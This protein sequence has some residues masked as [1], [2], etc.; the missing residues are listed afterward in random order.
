MAE[1]AQISRHSVDKSNGSFAESLHDSIYVVRESQSF[2]RPKRGDSS[3]IENDATGG[4]LAEKAVP[5]DNVGGKTLWT[6]EKLNYKK[7]GEWTLEHHQVG[8]LQK[9]VTVTSTQNKTGH[10]TINLAE[11]HRMRLRKLQIKLVHQAINM[12]YTGR[13]SEEG[14]MYSYN[15]V[16]TALP[17]LID[18]F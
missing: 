12:H 8:L 3:I 10:I 14:R 17:L 6:A 5:P 18:S 15:T 2:E 16:S 11:L 13:E 4:Q 1:G 9:H 7:A